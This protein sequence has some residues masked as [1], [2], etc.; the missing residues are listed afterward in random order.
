MH[1]S[2]G[3]KNHKLQRKKSNTVCV[4]AHARVCANS[5]TS[6]STVFG[7]VLFLRDLVWMICKYLF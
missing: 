1:D 7:F 5:I 4:R 2:V 6:L 3:E